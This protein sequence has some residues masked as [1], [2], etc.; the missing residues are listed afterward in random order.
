MD[1]ANTNSEGPGTPSAG[2]ML[3]YPIYRM[4]SVGLSEERAALRSPSPSFGPTVLR[5]VLRLPVDP[6]RD[7][8]AASLL[9]DASGRSVMKLRPGD[10]DVKL[11][12]PGIYFVRGPETGDAGPGMGTRKVILTR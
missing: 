5:G 9:L 4:S 8:Q 12:A 7:P 3:L 1:A 6:C 11:L 2:N 10:N